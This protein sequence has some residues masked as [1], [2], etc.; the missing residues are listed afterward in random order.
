M[1][2]S[3]AAVELGRVGGDRLVG[4]TLTW[5]LGPGRREQRR[6]LSPQISVLG[7]Q[8]L[9]AACFMERH[10]SERIRE[11]LML[12][13]GEREWEQHAYLRFL[14]LWPFH[15]HFTIGPCGP[16]VQKGRVTLCTQCH[17][18]L[19]LSL[20]EEVQGNGVASFS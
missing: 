10:L 20:K 17:V 12:T 15:P 13:K 9:L 4:K 2:T 8:N 16:A 18:L 5:S 6:G 7:G 3:L 19:F 11:A 14:R 1:K